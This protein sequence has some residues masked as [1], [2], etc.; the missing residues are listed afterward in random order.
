MIDW[1]TP[2]QWGI[3]VGVLAMCAVVA[4]GSAL[5]GE[6]FAERRREQMSSNAERYAEQ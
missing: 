3:L 1:L 5:V 4:G 6:A 2:A